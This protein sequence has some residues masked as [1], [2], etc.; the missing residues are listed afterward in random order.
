MGDQREG[1][2]NK[3]YI[4]PRPSPRRRPSLHRAVS[5]VLS[6]HC[7]LQTHIAYG[8]RESSTGVFCERELH[9]AERHARAGEFEVQC[10]FFPP[11]TRSIG[12]G[13]GRE[14]VQPRL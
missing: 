5:R 7:E 3:G 1:R 11:T 13:Q 10:V 9:C 4:S 14:N 2:H 8:G 6:R 12:T